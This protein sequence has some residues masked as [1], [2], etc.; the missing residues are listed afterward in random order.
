MSLRNN[1]L[2]LAPSCVWPRSVWGS[3]PEWKWNHW[4]T[5]TIMWDSETCHHFRPAHVTRADVISISASISDWN[6]DW[7]PVLSV[8]WLPCGVQ[9][10][11]LAFCKLMRM[12]CVV[13]D[14]VIGENHHHAVVSDTQNH[15]WEKTEEDKTQSCSVIWWCSAYWR[16][17]ARLVTR[18]TDNI[19]SHLKRNR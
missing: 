14:Y 16:G 1:F 2:G 19:W 7:K 8:L 5:L 15:G 18:A 3:K 12:M 4:T 13:G 6:Q 9:C 17:V 11:N 10:S